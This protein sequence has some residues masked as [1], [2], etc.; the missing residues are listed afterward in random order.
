MSGHSKWAGIKHKKAL[1][2]S[3]RGKLFGK[4]I[5]EITVSAKQGGGSLETNPRLR[6]AIQTA[7]DAN[8]PAEKMERAIKKGTGELPGTHYEE[9][10]ME[11]YGQGGVAVMLEIMTDNRNRTASEIK[12]LF[13]KGGGHLGES[14]CVA[15][16]FH[17]KGLITVSENKSSEDKLLEIS[18][19]AGAEDLKKDGDAFAITSTVDNFD[20]VKEAIAKANI[21]YN[22]AEI[23][24]LPQNTV[25]V[26][27]KT[28]EQVLRLVGTLEDHDDVQHVY[29]N[30]D[31]P[32]EM[33]EK[34]EVH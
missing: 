1:V 33:L 6:T 16:L 20:R 34:V 22:L 23:T 21:E 8:M 2:D 19:E 26:E 3:R 27:G 14:G 12:H 18:L 17:K 9:M 11:G 7:K 15:W 25:R 4:L 24:K 10:I 32:D 29:A 13:S 31:V 30:F 28:A 5:R